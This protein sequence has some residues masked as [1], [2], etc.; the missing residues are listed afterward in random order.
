[1]KIGSQQ[2]KSKGW[3]CTKSFPKKI[4]AAAENASGRS[5]TRVRGFLARPGWSFTGSGAPSVIRGEKAGT[6][7]CG[8]HAAV[9][10]F[11]KGKVL[12]LQIST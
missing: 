1:M 10:R 6:R 7:E 2:G 3:T 5:G 8:P 4:A 12:G 9:S 11:Q